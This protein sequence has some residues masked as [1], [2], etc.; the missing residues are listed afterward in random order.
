MHIPGTRWLVTSGLN[1]GSPAHLYTVDIRTQRAA[2]LFPIGTPTMMRDPDI[3][4]DCFSPPDLATI[5]ID[6]I[7]LRAGDDGQHLLYAANH[8]DR[9]AIEIFKIDTRGPVPAA[10][11]RLVKMPAGTRANAVVPLTDGGF[12]AGSFYD[13]RDEHAWVRMGRGEPSG[14]LW[15]WHAADGFR[16]I[17]A[18]DISGA[19]GLEI[20]ADE[21]TIYVSA[22]SGRALVILTGG[23]APSASSR[24]SSCPTISSAPPTAHCSSLVSE[25]HQD[26]GLQRPRMPTGLDRRARRPP[27]RNGHTGGDPSRQRAHQLCL[28]SA[29]GR[30]YALHHG[31][32]RS[33][34]RVFTHGIAAIASLSEMNSG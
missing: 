23:P 20:S 9:F 12:L 19:N 31:A 14:S 2:V 3:G 28:R 33:T 18:G 16:R 4:S 11:G 15:E 10:S 25:R 21:T 13:P 29:R 30:R 7:N 6:G 5:S 22:W 27:A 17:D 1:I 26:R 32:R 34:A 8:G 24:W